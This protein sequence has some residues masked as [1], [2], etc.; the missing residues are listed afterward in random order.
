[1]ERY[2]HERSLPPLEEV[3]EQLEAGQLEY[4]LG[5]GNRDGKRYRIVQLWGPDGKTITGLHRIIAASALGRWVDRVDEVDHINHDPSD[6]RAENL[7][8]VSHSVN[9]ERRRQRLDASNAAN[10]DKVRNRISRRKE[11]A[12]NQEV[13]TKAAIDS[14]LAAR[15]RYVELSFRY[16]PPPALRYSSHPTL[17]PVA[18]TFAPRSQSSTVRRK[19]GV[20]SDDLVA[21]LRTV[22]SLEELNGM[23]NRRNICPQL[24]E[25]TEDE[26]SLIESRRRFLEKQ[27]N[28]SY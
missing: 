12:R 18:R 7:E 19:V 4:F 10:P 3:L 13:A 17:K 5:P 21:K 14:Y 6:N 9:R 25:R 22:T 20:R 1:M 27:R 28:R 24:C 23:L 15:N 8:I 26:I 11:K 16:V 2:E